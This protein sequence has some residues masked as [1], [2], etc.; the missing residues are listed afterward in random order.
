MSV[1]IIN[2]L[3]SKSKNSNILNKNK[4]ENLQKIDKKLLSMTIPKFDEY[5]FLLKHNYNI[6]QLKFIAK[7]YK[8][9]ITGN[10]QELISRTY[11]HLHLSHFALKI[12][13][14]IRGYLRRKY[15]IMHGPA[16]KNRTLCTN[17][18][19]FLSMDE[20]TTIPNEQFFSFKDD[21]GFIY[22]FDIISLYNLIYNCNGA[23]KN[24]FNQKQITSKVIENFRT[25]LRISRVLKINIATKIPDITKEISDKKSLELRALT[26]FQNIDALGHYS[27]YQWF[28][29]LNKNLLIKFTRELVDI[30]KYRANLSIQIKESICYPS[31]EPF[32]TLPKLDVLEKFDNLDEIRKIILVSME[33]L[34]NR[35]ID[36]DSKNLGAYFILCA[37]TLVNIDAATSL[38]YLYEAAHYM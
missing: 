6:K 7:A 29:T 5:D 15:N 1:E 31:G 36:K 4:S 2:P 26:L 38:P 34:V 24:P 27:N 23:I 20:L 35:G 12:Q 17:N 16:F 37:L 11:V 25:L 13:K 9:K 3:T 22:G 14:I 21:D 18:F 33:N 28:L 19:D 30:W 8:L 32:R 10:K